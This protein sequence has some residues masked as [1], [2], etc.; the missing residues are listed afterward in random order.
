MKKTKL[1]LIL[2]LTLLI[3]LI[4]LFIFINNNKNLQEMYIKNSIIHPL[5]QFADNMKIIDTQLEDIIVAREVSLTELEDL[6][7]TVIQ[8]SQYLSDFKI[9]YNDFIENEEGLMLVATIPENRLIQVQNNLHNLKEKLADINFD[10]NKN[11]EINPKK[12]ELLNNSQVIIS[13]YKEIIVS[14]ENTSIYEMIKNKSDFKRSNQW[15]DFIKNLS[16]DI[17]L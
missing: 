1:I 8:T 5:T 14:L 9:N 16:N 15:L 10:Q 2:I 7:T 4:T 6:K 12:L 13:Y 17:E 3:M 11:Y